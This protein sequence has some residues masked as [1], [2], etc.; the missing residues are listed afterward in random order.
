MLELISATRLRQKRISTLLF[1]VFASLLLSSASANENRAS[2]TLG[3]A[4]F[5]TYVSNDGEPARLNAIVS[6][7]FDSTELDIRLHVMRDAFLGSALL[8]GKI[9]G[10]FAY[11]NFASLLL[12]SA[13]ANENRASVTLGAAPFETYVSN[14]GEPARLNAIVSEAFDS[15]ELDIRLHVMRDA[16]LGSALL[17]GKI[18]GEFAYVNLGEDNSQFILSDIYLPLYLYAVSKRDNV[19]HITLF[20][21]LKD[22]R[23]AIENRF[24]NTPE[25]R[26]L[27]EVK[28]S[29]NPS[30]FDA[31]RQLADERAP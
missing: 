30:T 17:T 7:A 20:P 29:R 6:E 15:T 2:V 24:A 10:E 8:T 26:M 1:G 14:D 12:S 22:N 21:H 9:D 28:W 16:F 31:F 23:V 18:D 4:P 5:E 27:K 11:V 25:L 19:N 3:A 13:S